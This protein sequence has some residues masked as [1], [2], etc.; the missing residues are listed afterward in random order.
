MREGPRKGLRVLHREEDLGREL[1]QALTPEQKK[2]A[3]VDKV[4]YKDILTAA[5]RKASVEGQPSG[6]PVSKMNAKQKAML[7]AVIDE[8]IHSMPEQIAERRTAQLKAAGDKLFFAWA[9]EEQRGA[10]HYYRIQAP[11]FL[12]EYDN[13][14][15]N[16]NHIHAVW[17]DY[18]GDFGLDLL[19][20]HYDTADH[21]KTTNK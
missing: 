18:E 13:T 6:L 4:A 21:H 2:T 12:I 7:M 16:A 14:Q 9:G 19:K 5:S 10:P 1:I 8:Y 17:R 11:T 20:Q 15:N 3:I